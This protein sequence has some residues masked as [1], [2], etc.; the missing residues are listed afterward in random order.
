MWRRVAAG[1]PLRGAPKGLQLTHRFSLHPAPLILRVSSFTTTPTFPKPPGS[2]ADRSSNVVSSGDSR[3]PLSLEAQI[4][5]HHPPVSTV[6]PFTVI[7]TPRTLPDL[8]QGLPSPEVSF[9]TESV[10]PPP[11]SAEAHPVAVFPEFEAPAP[12]L[13]F[14]MVPSSSVPSLDESILQDPLDHLLNS[15]MPHAAQPASPFASHE[16]PEHPYSRSPHRTADHQSRTRGAWRWSARKLYGLTPPALPSVDWRDF[17]PRVLYGWLR[18]NS[19]LV[20]S[21]FVTNAIVSALM[22]VMLVISLFT[23]FRR[24]V[25]SHA[26][27]TSSDVLSTT[28]RAEPVT[29]QAQALSKAVVDAILTDPKSVT[30]VSQL[31]L[32]VLQMPQTKEQSEKLIVAVFQEERVRKNTGALFTDLIGLPVV[33]DRADRIG[34]AAA[35]DVLDS[36]A[37]RDWLSALFQRTFASPEMQRSIGD[38][39]WKATWFSLTPGMFQ[40]SRSPQPPDPPAGSPSSFLTPAPPPDETTPPLVPE[41]QNPS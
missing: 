13:P 35:S 2:D 20:L 16:N 17:H 40:G 14:T 10:P 18:H 37:P 6:L 38:A 4:S 36:P 30:L 11:S 29:A 31:L 15:E 12:A 32:R 19:H 9:P 7:S 23:L 3:K 24:S 33:Q 5:G 8:S 41:S 27:A 1:F 21:Y 25:I 39:L 34:Q 22:V 26:S 28:L